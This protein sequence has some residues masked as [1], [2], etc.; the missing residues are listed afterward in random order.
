MAV[1]NTSGCVVLRGLGLTGLSPATVRPKLSNLL[2]G[3]EGGGKENAPAPRV[4]SLSLTGQV[5]SDL[6]GCLD[7][8]YH[9]VR[10]SPRRGVCEAEEVEASCVVEGCACA[11][12]GEVSCEAEGSSWDQAE[13]GGCEL[14]EEAEGVM[15]LRIQEVLVRK[16]DVGFVEV[17]LPDGWEVRE[18]IDFNAMNFKVILTDWVFPDEVDPVGVDEDCDVAV[19]VGDDVRVG[20]WW[21]GRDR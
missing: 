6:A 5:C 11:C 10:Q 7:G 20:G 13:F 21:F 15:R 14:E 9:L 2:R 8:W 18:V 17:E 4:E 19:G 16:P 1:S 12:G 3:G